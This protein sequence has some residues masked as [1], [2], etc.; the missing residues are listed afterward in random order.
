M[1]WRIVRQPNGRFARWSDVVDTFTRFDMSEREA[2]EE[3]RNYPGMGALE[4]AEKVERAKRDEDPYT[5]K[6]RPGDGLARWREC[7]RVIETVHGAEVRRVVEEEG[8]E[9]TGTAPA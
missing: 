7:L 5:G 3:C 9:D 2:V 1:A 4:A 6:A 8:T